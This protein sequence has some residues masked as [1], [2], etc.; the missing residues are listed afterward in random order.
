MS[1]FI[2]FL[3]RPFGMFRWSFVVVLAV[4]LTMLAGCSGSDGVD[5]TKEDQLTLSPETLTFSETDAASN[6]VTVTATE[7]LTWSLEISPDEGVS[8]NR[9]SGVGSGS[10][11]I[12]T[13]PY[14]SGVTIRAVH[15]Y[16]DGR[17]P[18][19]SNATQVTRGKAPDDPTDEVSLEVIPDEIQFNPDDPAANVVTVRSNAAWKAT[20]Q[21]SGLAF[22]PA[23][24]EGDGTIQITA[25]PANETSTITVTAG[26]GDQAVTREVSVTYTPAPVEA[27]LIYYEDFDGTPYSDWADKSTSWQNP[28]GPGASAVSYTTRRARL[29]NEQFGSAGRYPEA[30]GVNHMRVWFDQDP[31]FVVNEISLTPDQTNLTLSMGSSFT[32]SD[33]RI[34]LSSDGVSWKEISYQ[35]ATTYNYWEYISV[36][37]TLA[38]PVDK[39]Y[40]RLAPHGSQSYGINFDDLM[41]STGP[42]GQVVS[43][44]TVVR[45]YRW[46]EL[47]LEAYSTGD[48]VVNTHWATTVVSGQHV[49]NF[50]YCYDT[51]RH[52]PLWIAHPQHACY[53]EGSGRTNVWAKDPYMTDWQQAIMYP[54][55]GIEYVSLYSPDL[56]VQWGRGHMLMSNYRGGAGSELN[57]QT[58]YS[59]N[60]S[61]QA[62]AAFNKL[63]ND[64]EI[65]IQDYYVC[66]DT[67]YCVSGAYFGNENTVAKDATYTYQGVRYYIEEY[68]KD[69]IVPTHYYKL[70]LRTRDGNTGKAIQECDASEL[71]SVG[72]WFSHSEVDP[73]SNSTSP[74]LG[75]AYMKSVKEIEALTGFTF[76]PDV[77]ESVKE[78]CNP[79]D[80]GY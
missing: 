58:F 73:V 12:E 65:W 6:T 56:D 51:R 20:T 67:L 24:G 11:R 9:T 75:P 36:D 15:R 7:G 18:L 63:W 53:E 57:A 70:I 80:W 78:Q 35:G 71:I 25:S 72:F 37:F 68:S 76:F 31:Y 44:E 74:T 54:I 66:A 79:S 49:R 61:P 60:V 28:V 43:L 59:S 77:P 34:M 38:A 52:C 27:E 48:Y 40:I 4:V 1:S 30:S 13:M 5:D 45:D 17:Q 33:C 2:L 50:T 29:Y 10:F 55:A 41:L 8:V 39:L 46:A 69:C 16:D 23:E 64:A 32:S 21:S 22:T 42:G 26:E 62:G 14:E 19:R 47:P 3:K